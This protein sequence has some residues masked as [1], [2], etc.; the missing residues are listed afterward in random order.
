M[1]DPVSSEPGYDEY[2]RRIV[3]Q[4]RCLVTTRFGVRRA[5]PDH[6]RAAQVA[7]RLAINILLYVMTQRGWP[8]RFE[9]PTAMNLKLL[10]TTRMAAL[11]AAVIACNVSLGAAP[12][13]FE[14]QTA[15]PESRGLS[16]SELDGFRAHLAAHATKAFLLVREDRIV[17]EWYSAD[18]SAT[19]PH[20]TASMAKALV[21]GMAVAVAMT[22]GRLTLDDPAAKFIP[23]WRNDPMKS[24]ITLRH[25]G[26]HTS[27][28]DDAEAD[29]LPHDKLT[30]W[31]GDFWKRLPVPR[32]AFTVSRDVAPVVFPPGER[33][34]YSNPGIAML[35]YATTAAL[36]NAPEKDLRTLLKER[37]MRPIGVADNEWSVGYGQTVMVDGLP[38]VGS[39][40]GGNFT[41]RATARVGRLMLREG[42]WEGRRL[43]SREAVRAV[44]A[45]AGFPGGGAIGW[46]SN[47][48]G[49]VAS[50]PRDAFWGAGAQHQLLLVVPSLKLIAV[51]N[52]G[53][54]R[55]EAYDSARDEMFF[56]P[57]MKAIG[58]EKP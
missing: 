21:G 22:D 48:E 57:L 11:C 41:A 42:D 27:G 34:L 24:K 16:Q 23:Q 20:F 36:K 29:K 50:L 7:D 39:W 15:A 28:I 14:W 1:R 54:L 44:T 10:S 45:D 26:S 46:W 43:I 17:Y 30:G 4:I 55:G 49:G 38:L 6:G 37:V 35:A 52:G 31:K 51:R 32:D 19:K 9:L 47:N 33:I 18:H 56:Q 8:Y 58:A 3:L 13:G 53:A 5:L 25:L 2:A 40:G 12:G